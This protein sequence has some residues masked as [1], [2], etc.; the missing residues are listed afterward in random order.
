MARINETNHDFLF[1]FPRKLVFKNGCINRLGAV[2]ENGFERPLLITGGGSLK[3]SGKYEIITGSLKDKKIDYIEYS[4]IGSEPTPE[5]VDA[6]AEFAVRSEAKSIIAIGGGSVID[7]GKAVAALAVNEKG[8]ENYLE[9]IGKNF[10]IVNDPLPFAA[11]PTTAGSGAEVTKNAVITSY[12]KKYKKSFRDER[13]AAKIV[14]A[15]PSLTFTLPRHETAYGGMD[16][17]CQLLESAVTKKNNPFAGALSCYFLPKAAASIE[18][19]VNDPDDVGA[20]SMMLASSIASGLAL[21]N[22][23]LGAVH[24]FASGMGGLF[25]IPHGLICAVLLPGVCRMNADRSPGIYAE[26]APL[27]NEDGSDNE[28][29]MID[30][31][32]ELNSRL[33]IPGDFKSMKLSDVDPE[34]IVRLSRGSSMSGNPVDFS[35]DELAVFIEKYL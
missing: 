31:L 24:G 28:T 26:I 17:V 21:A 32:F 18:I 10:K 34:E 15:D 16:A 27:L 14:L 30:T 13:L 33:N 6:A 29:K 23:G 2:I 12:N 4:G 25:D 19:A 9:G 11:V 20:R 8:V 5:I 22:S 3:N 7:T 1:L 35:D